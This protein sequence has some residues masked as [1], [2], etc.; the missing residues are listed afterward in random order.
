MFSCLFLKY[1]SN[2]EILSSDQEKRVIVILM[3]CLKE[4]Y[5][6]L[7]FFNDSSLECVCGI[8]NNVNLVLIECERERDTQRASKRDTEREIWRERDTHTERRRAKE[9][10]RKR[11]TYRDR[12]RQ[13]VRKREKKKDIILIENIRNLTVWRGPSLSATA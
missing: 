11:D 2:L 13:R 3:E 4:C 6:Y 8:A 12:G 5:L 1:T 7:F 10:Q 9:R